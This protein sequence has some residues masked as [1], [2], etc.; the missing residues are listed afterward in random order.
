ME[1]LV[2]DDSRV[3]SKLLQD[4]LER[5]GYRVLVAADGEQALQA[6]RAHRPSLVI[7]DIV[8][9]V[10]N[11]YELCQALKS[12]AAL[13]HIPVVLLTTLSRIEDI[14][15]GLQAQADYYLTKPYSPEYLLHTIHT[16]YDGSSKQ[17]HPDDNSE[18]LEVFIDGTS[19][20]VTTS[21]RQML[22]L[23]L[24]TYGNAV[25]QN[26]ELLQAQRELQALNQ[27]LRQ[28]TQRIEEQQTRLQEA[29]E[30][31]HALAT[32]DGLTGVK[33]HRAFKERLQE[34]L[35]RA[36][37][38]QMPL[39][40]VLL[41][42]D[43]FKQYNDSFGHPAGDEILAQVGQLLVEKSRDTDFAARYG[44]EEFAILLPNTDCEYS[45]V[46]AERLRV[47]LESHEWPLRPITASF[48]VSTFP[49]VGTTSEAAA[50]EP[51]AAADGTMLIA[52]ADKALYCSKEHGRN[53]VT[54]IRQVAAS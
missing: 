4:L 35:Q 18:G 25:Q 20:R 51:D 40:L 48:G 34:E 31:L 47:A 8:M 17:H 21:R 32:H 6:A 2:V 7:S 22:N 41:D 1:I 38:Y 42:V 5:H 50:E 3:Q 24:S 39:S 36:E 43:R 13:S 52:A 26:R 54:H 33:N 30:R 9:P 23:L 29:N 37:R 46:L 16:V 14:L 11:G 12:D 15:L 19:H 53:R 28:Q 45:I 49:P 27:Q 10:M 44:G